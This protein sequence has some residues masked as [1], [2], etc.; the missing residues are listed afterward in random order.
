MMRSPFLGASVAGAGFWV[1]SVFCDPIFEFRWRGILSAVRAARAR[2]AAEVRA[3]SFFRGNS[4]FRPVAVGFGLDTIFWSSSTEIAPR[5]KTY[6]NVFVASDLG[7]IASNTYSDKKRGETGIRWGK[8]LTATHRIFAI[9]TRIQLF[10][11][12]AGQNPPIDE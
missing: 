1:P 7:R 8:N 3:A 2:G 12:W 6:G 9:G 4:F 5:R 11:A 10:L